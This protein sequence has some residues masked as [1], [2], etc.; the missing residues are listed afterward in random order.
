MKIGILTFV[1]AANYG[2]AYQ[3]YALYKF[4]NQYPAVECDHIDYRPLGI[5]K[6]YSPC[7][8]RDSNGINDYLKRNVNYLYH[9]PKFLRFKQ[10]RQKH[11]QLS[12]PC[13]EES[14][15]SRC[16]Q[17]DRIIVGSDQV[18]NIQCTQN[19]WHFLLDFISDCTKK[20]S[21]AASFA[22]SRLPEQYIGQYERL[23]NTFSNISVREQ[24]GAEI[25][26]ELTGKSCPVVLDP[27]FLL[28]KKD[29]EKFATPFSGKPYILVYQLY[30]TDAL[31][32]FAQKLSQRTELPLKVNTTSIRTKA[33]RVLKAG[34]CSN[35]SP[36]EFVSLL[37]NASY[38][39]TN[40]FHGTAL[41]ILMN[42]PFFT[43]LVPEKY[44]VNSRFKSLLGSLDL[45]DR[46]I[47]NAECH[48]WNK[49]ADY[50]KI[51]RTLDVYISDSMSYI[52]RILAQ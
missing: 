41:A 14:I 30:Y 10:F 39:V 18:W 12:E 2:A 25:V 16:A 35:A 23:L 52:D 45:M 46:V 33:Y 50:D 51:N 26:K 27:V 15:K 31:L 28:K 24:E 19:D 17:Y 13:D 21:Y 6:Q 7:S 29:W 49:M 4:I 5:M 47:H 44:G 32:E 22:L 40:S 3:S 11:L 37:H 38:I 36:E 9:I 20:N 8:I 1:N 48:T 42:R 34:D 43:E